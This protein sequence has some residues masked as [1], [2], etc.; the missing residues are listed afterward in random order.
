MALVLLLSIL[1]L[2]GFLY[3][4]SVNE[5]NLR[6]IDQYHQQVGASTAAQL[7]A[8]SVERRDPKLFPLHDR[9]WINQSPLLFSLEDEED[10]AQPAGITAEQRK[11]IMEAVRAS[12]SFRPPEVMDFETSFI[13]APILSVG[14]K[15]ELPGFDDSLDE[16]QQLLSW[17]QGMEFVES[18][19]GGGV[20]IQE[21]CRL[22]LLDG[23]LESSQ[24]WL[25][26][27]DEQ[28][29]NRILITLA[30]IEPPLQAL[31]RAI[32]VETMQILDFYGE[33]LGREYFTAYLIPGCFDLKYFLDRNLEWSLN[34]HDQEEMALHS[35]TPPF[36]APVS[37]VVKINFESVFNRTRV[38]DSLLLVTRAAFEAMLAKKREQEWQPPEGIE[39]LEGPDGR[40]R[41]HVT[42][43]P[44]GTDLY[45]PE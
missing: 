29:L 32:Q 38:T 39:R 10:P 26:L 34:P 4:E 25:N 14:K 17:R 27:D 23:F 43:G 6:R 19:L 22:S 9:S 7:W 24:R 1:L 45:L 11:Q 18:L 16:K 42:D 15:W 20:L 35:E 40:V 30:R 2:L 12:D 5:D 13:L 28:E 41:I 36:Y 31:V 33:E 37:S 44:A 21:L 3:I 8:L